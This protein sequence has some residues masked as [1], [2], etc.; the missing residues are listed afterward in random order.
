MSD[1]VS[2]D[3]HRNAKAF[4]KVA[5]WMSRPDALQ[6]HCGFNLFQITANGIFCAKCE[7]LVQ[8]GV[9]HVALDFTVAM[10]DPK[11]VG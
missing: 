9:R 7:Q 4:M 6:C 10:K 2:L 3:T 11:N 8:F 5:E 1:P